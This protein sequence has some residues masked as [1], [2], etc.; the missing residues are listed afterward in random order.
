MKSAKQPKSSPAGRKRRVPVS[1]GI[2]RRASRRSIWDKPR[3][4]AMRQEP[5]GSPVRLTRAE[6]QAIAREAFGKRPDL[7]P[8][9]EYVRRLKPIWRGLLKARNG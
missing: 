8:G 1:N 5:I 7:P 9:S 2:R 4:N 3:V 6:A